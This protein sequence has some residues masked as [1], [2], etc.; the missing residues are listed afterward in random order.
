[1]TKRVLPSAAIRAGSTARIAKRAPGWFDCSAPPRHPLRNSAHHDGSWFEF[2][3]TT[4]LTTPAS[5]LR[6]FS[7]RGVQPKYDGSFPGF[8]L[9]L[10]PML[11]C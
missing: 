1:M 7:S 11:G 2:F 6:S 3:R 4:T 5:T 8:H 9:I 10:Q